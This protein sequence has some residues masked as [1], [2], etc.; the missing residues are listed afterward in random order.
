[1]RGLFDVVPAA[2]CHDHDQVG[3]AIAEYVAVATGNAPIATTVEATQ[4]AE[5]RAAGGFPEPQN[6]R[7]LYGIEPRAIQGF[8]AY[9]M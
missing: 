7:P 9:L 3:L 1:M 5:K 8:L 2:H 4:R 6:A